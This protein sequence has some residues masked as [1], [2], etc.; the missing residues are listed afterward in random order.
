MQLRASEKVARALAGD[1]PAFGAQPR[2]RLPDDRAGD[3][4]QFRERRFSREPVVR[5]QA[6]FLDQGE[7]SLVGEVGQ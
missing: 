6:I 7:D 2:Q 3:A 4:D 5:R 1:D